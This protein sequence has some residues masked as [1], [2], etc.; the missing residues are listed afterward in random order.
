[1][2][3]AQARYRSLVPICIAKWRVRHINVP[4]RT[5]VIQAGGVDKGGET[6]IS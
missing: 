1:M 2:P 5:T 6:D 4:E 3:T